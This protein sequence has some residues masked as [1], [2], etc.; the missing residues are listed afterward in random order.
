ME[1]M[2]RVSWVADDFRAA[3]AAVLRRR[4]IVTMRISVSDLTSS[5]PA[6]YRISVLE[7]EHSSYPAS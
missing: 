7:Q 1:H 4:C 2:K 6:T 3:V 5:S